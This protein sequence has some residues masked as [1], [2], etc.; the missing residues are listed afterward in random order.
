MRSLLAALLLAAPLHAQ[1]AAPPAYDLILRGGT[2]VNGTGAPRVRADVAIARGRIAAIGDLGRAS[3]T[4]ELDVR[5]LMVAPGFINIH[6]HAMPTVLPTAANMLTQGVT[7]ELLNADGSGPP[8]IASQLARYAA[9]G[10]AVNI[11]ASA[12]FNSVWASVMGPSDKRPTAADTERM[13]AMLRANL[14]QGAFGISAGLDYKPAYFATTDEAT[15]VLS[16]ARGWRTFFPNHDRLTPETGFSSL[17]G[18]EETMTIANATGLVPVFTHMKLQGHEQGSAA[19]ILQRMTDEA[20]AGRWVAADVYPYLAGQTALAALIIPGWAQDGGVVK[21]R[22]RFADPALR[23]RIITETDVAIRA[24]LGSGSSILLNETGRRLPDIMAEMGVTSAGEA[25]VRI[26]DTSTPSAIMTF[27][28]EADLRQLLAHPAV[29]IACDCGA[30][31]MPR[32]H[33]RGY[34]TYPRILGHYVRDTRLLTWEQAIHKMTA[35]PAAIMGLTDRGLLAPGMAADIT[36]FDSAT[37]I[38]RATYE[39][40]DLLSEGIRLVLVNGVVALRDGVVTGARGGL[41]LRRS[42][43]MPSRPAQFDSA[44]TLR[45]QGTV[46]SAHG[47]TA[48]VTVDVSHTA[49]AREATGSVRV[50]VPSGAEWTSAALGVVQRAAHWTSLTGQFTT[51]DGA[52]AF[53]LI[54]DG[55]ASDTRDG[56][57]QLLL[58]ADG[59]PDLSGVVQPTG[60]DDRTRMVVRLDSIAT[61]VIERSES[62][63]LAVAV[64]RGRDTLLF[65]GYGASDLEN[66]VPVTPGTV[67]R[68]GSVT[69][70]FTSAAIMQ[71]VEQ[72]KVGLDD[73]ST[74]Y[75][76]NFPTH[77]RRVLVRHLLNHTSGI[78][79]YTDIGPRFG[80]VSRL[81]LPPDSLLAIVASDSLMFEPGTHFYY[82]NTGYF[83]LGQVIERTTGTNYGR[84]LEQSLLKNTGLSNTLYCDSRRLIPNRAKGYDRVGSSFVNTSFLSMDLPNAAGSLCSTVGDLVSWTQ[85]LHGGR[86][87]NSA[88][89]TQMTSPVTLSSGRPMRYGYALTVDTVGGHA[90]VEHGGGINGFSAYLSYAPADSLVVAVLTN[91]AGAPSSRVAQDLV[92][93]ALG[94][95]PAAAAVVQ[96]LP[97]TPAERARYVG[98]YAVTQPDGT[99]RTSRVFE[100]DGQLHFAQASGAGQRMRAQG[101]HTFVL[102]SG[103]RVVFDV[104]GDAAT[105]LQWSAGTLRAL[106]GVRVRDG[107]R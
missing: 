25:V 70:Q 46:Q 83:M 22:E 90:L 26:L 107:A 38:D 69:K 103:V 64:V 80:R 89:L 19:Q 2:V 105:G 15:A 94:V 77:G 75:L 20:R 61:A 95:A 63:G 96:D 5:G 92:R 53:T 66:R 12:G 14:E 8:D 78:P 82:N 72:G 50:R 93:A 81:D 33:P 74:K 59:L 17:R 100:Q 40:S 76:P 57:A 99:R 4:S 9:S 44:R 37:V 68:V 18:M 49:G 24:R 36:V 54:V 43:H 97:L 67:F 13:R 10:L 34:G 7:T 31:N 88:S 3:A 98:E 45:V 48:A 51:P 35:L 87:V 91:T 23:A 102:A 32:A 58:Q 27:G 55:G 73:V 71:L 86:V 11:A 6:S 60:S 1:P 30:W 104:S 41:T 106:E 16:V 56:T 79:S 29:A 39:Q 84:Y 42:M 101:A 65:K 28:A 85:Q 21:M 62:A 47:E 52:R